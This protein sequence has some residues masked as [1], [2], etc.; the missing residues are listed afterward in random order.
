MTSQEKAINLLYLFLTYKLEKGKKNHQYIHLFLLNVLVC[1]NFFQKT[2]FDPAP[3]KTLLG[4][5]HDESNM[6]LW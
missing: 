6:S 3:S 5:W 2:I 1:F 4:T